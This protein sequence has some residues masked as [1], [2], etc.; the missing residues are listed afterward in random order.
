MDHQW[1][2]AEPH[3]ANEWLR[4]LAA[5][6]W[7]AGGWA[8]DLFLG[9]VTRTH[10]DLDV[11]VLREDFRALREALPGWQFFEAK[12]GRLR[13]L[14]IDAQPRAD[15]HSLWCRREGSSAWQLEVMNGEEWVYRREPTIRRPFEEILRRSHSGL[16]YLAPEV[17]LLYK[18]KQTR[19]R[20]NADFRSVIPRLSESARDW[21][22]EALII[23]QSGHAWVTEINGARGV[24]QQAVAADGQK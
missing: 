6:W 14:K 12:N 5:R 17:Q 2:P 3:H 13:E 7:V 21:L 16:S 18:S 22:L 19:P 10:E 23:A 8:V 15:V 20:D 4:G 11:G 24:G 1:F 9:Q